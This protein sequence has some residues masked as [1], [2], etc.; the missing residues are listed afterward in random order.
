MV[1]TSVKTLLK[2]DRYNNSIVSSFLSQRK[3]KYWYRDL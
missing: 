1:Y 2:L 3:K